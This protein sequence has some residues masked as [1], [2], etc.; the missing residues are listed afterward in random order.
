MR[1]LECLRMRHFGLFVQQCKG[2]NMDFLGFMLA[3][4]VFT[5]LVKPEYLGQWIRTVIEHTKDQ[6]EDD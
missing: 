5:V 3:G 6:P 1:F 2:I 4:V